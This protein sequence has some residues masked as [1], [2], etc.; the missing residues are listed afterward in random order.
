VPS[1]SHVNAKRLKGTSFVQLFDLFDG[2]S[3]SL[4][5]SQPSVN[6]G[7]FFTDY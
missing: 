5:R 2:H 1:V 4:N 3:K 6:A 7:V